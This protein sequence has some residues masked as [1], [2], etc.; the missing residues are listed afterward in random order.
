MPS[1]SISQNIAKRIESKVSRNLY[2]CVHSNI[3]NNIQNVEAGQLCG[4]VHETARSRVADH[5]FQLLDLMT[6][7]TCQVCLFACLKDQKKREMEKELQCN[8]SPSAGGVG[9]GSF[10]SPSL[11]VSLWWGLKKKKRWKHPKYL[12]TDYWIN[13]LC[14]IH[15]MEYYSTLKREGN[16]DT[17]YK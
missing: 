9:I 3:I 12:L 4:L 2:A 17:L 10:S 1:N 13:R 8:H 15:T 11:S 14:Y 16:S 5:R 7:K 6:S